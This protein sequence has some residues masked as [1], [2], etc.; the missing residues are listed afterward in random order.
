[1]VDLLIHRT[2]KRISAGEDR[3]LG[4]LLKENGVNFAVFSETAQQMFLIL[5]DS[6]QGPPTDVI[7]M[8]RTGDIWHVFVHEA[9][10]GQLYGYKAQ[11]DYKPEEGKRFNPHKLLIDPYAKALSGKSTGDSGLLFGYDL[12][13]PDKDMAMDTRDNAHIVPKGI[14]IDDSFDWGDNKRPGI[15]IE[16]YVIYESHLKGFTAHVSSQTSH[17]GTYLGFVEKIPYL[18]ELGVNAVEFMPIHEFYV[19]DQ[20]RKKGLTDFWGYNSIAFFAPEFSYGTASSP[21]C[22]VREFKTLVRELHAAGIEVIL[23]VVY[24]HTGEGNELG[25]TLSFKGLDNQAYYRLQP[26]PQKPEERMRNYLNVTGTGNT[27]RIEHPMVLRLVLESLRYWAGVMHVDGF[28][29]DLASVLGVAKGE[30]NRTSPFFEEIAKDPVLSHMK[31]IAEPWDL[32]M[33]QVGNFPEG[34][35]EWNG[36]FRDTARK[37]LRGDGEVGPMAR[38]ISG[39]PDLYEHNNRKPFHSINFI[40]CHD[41]FTLHDLFSYNQKHNEAN[42]EDNRDGNQE[43]YSWNCGVEGETDNPG[44]LKLRRQMARNAF[45]LL[46]FST[47]TPMF[48]YGDEILRTQKGNNNAYCQDNE[49]TWMNWDVYLRNADLFDFCKK[50]IAW[51]KRYPILQR[52]RFFTGEDSSGD[53]V[54][55]VSWFSRTL[56]PP[57]WDD[58]RTKTIY[59]RLSCAEALLDKEERYLLVAFHMYHR[60]TVLW[61]PRHKNLKW[62]RMIDTSLEGRASCLSPGQEELLPHQEKILCCPRSVVV[63]TGKKPDS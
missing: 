14:V 23:D 2:Q 19:L 17:P 12:N 59:Y 4:G 56:G 6:P 24:N 18:K 1:M 42:Q 44:I 36:S 48:L 22:Q 8:N 61:L 49:L 63:L 60:K 43:N 32:T 47:G 50:V 40:D 21:G 45:C 29:F 33:Y 15:P 10:A 38:R 9:R 7:R 5:F 26:N 41:G 46:L 58:G 20:L 28:R 3:F 34:W 52:W 13:H 16:R 35:S 30:F 11:G 62:F 53:G 27:I 39:S 55:D 57:A 31:M 37:F 51:R 54:P 25:P